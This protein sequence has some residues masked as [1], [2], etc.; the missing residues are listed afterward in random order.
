MKTAI[1][2]GAGFIGSHLADSLIFR[3]HQV[4]ILDNFISGK[5]ENVPAGAE[6]IRADI[7]SEI[8]PSAFSGCG[9]VFHLAA[10][11]SVKDS[12]LKAKEGFV[13]NVA[14]T[15]NVLEACR[16]ADVPKFVFT[17]SSVVYGEAKAQPTPE[18]YPTIPISNYGASKLAGE[19]YCFSYAHTYGMKATVVRLANIFGERSTH[20]VMFDFYRKLKKNPKILEILGDGKQSK[21]YLHVSDCVSAILLAFGKQEKPAD[22]F[23][24][25]SRKKKSVNEIA[26]LVAREM[27]VSPKFEYTGGSRGWAGDVSEMLLDTRKMESLGWKPEIAF[28]EGVGKYVSWLKSNY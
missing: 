21:S 14:G 4:S 10:D 28:E 13:A 27:G 1:T 18:D 3:G 16:K 9:A 7:A 22:I 5:K 8:S 23:N 17:S 19:A 25:G 24:I 26:S 12:A 2:G 6:I 20:G 15:F 11:P